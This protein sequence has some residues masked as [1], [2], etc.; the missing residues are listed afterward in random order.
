MLLR[1]RIPGIDAR[2][3]DAARG[4]EHLGQKSIGELRWLAAHGV[5][6]VLVGSVAAVIRGQPGAS[7]PV[8]IVAAPYRRNF[9]RLAR[10]LSREQAR[11]RLD[12]GQPDTSP[13]K[14]TAEKLA[15][16][17]RWTLTC[18]GHDL[19]IEGVPSGA[20]SYQELL[21]EAGRFEPA[22]NVSVDVAAPE[23]IEH[24]EHLRRTGAAPEIK[25]SRSSRIE[26]EN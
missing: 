6:Y 10:A 2:P 25:I 13:A 24:Y 16:G 4:F 8:A 20:P 21:Y 5:D 14:L 3:P 1:H 7:G 23:H 9:E 17:G 19:D 22:E 18:R 12:I 15:R 26:H 11:I